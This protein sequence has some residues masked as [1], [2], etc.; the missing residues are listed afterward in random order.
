MSTT[1]AHTRKGVKS[2]N[3]KR[4]IESKIRYRQIYNNE[5]VYALNL[6]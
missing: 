2:F 1:R 6:K 3:E 5:K 4:G